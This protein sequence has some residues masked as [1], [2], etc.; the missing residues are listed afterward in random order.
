MKKMEMKTVVVVVV[1]VAAVI[2]A[3]IAQVVMSRMKLR[4]KNKF[5][6][7]NPTLHHAIHAQPKTSAMKSV[8]EIN[9]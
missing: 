1:V 4:P 9:G 5:V 6:H 3:R 8:A 7:Y 2:A